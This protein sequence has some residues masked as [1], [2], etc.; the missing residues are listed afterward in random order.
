MRR[1][2]E[3]IKAAQLQQRGQLGH[4]VNLRPRGSL[5]RSTRLHGTSGGVG[6]RRCS[7]WACTVRAATR[8]PSNGSAQTA[9]RLFCWFSTDR[10]QG[11]VACHRGSNARSVRIRGRCTFFASLV[12]PNGLPGVPDA[13]KTYVAFECEARRER[14][15]RPLSLVAPPR[16]VGA[17]ACTRWATHS[18]GPTPV[19]GGG[20][21]SFETNGVV[22]TRT[23]RRASRARGH[24]CGASAACACWSSCGCALRFM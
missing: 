19:G 2:S 22:L 10:R 12:V 13:A 18:S 15:L 20:T 4:I 7:F 9:R 16:A 17:A 6:R 5:P 14:R 24:H 11:L 1:S 3:P 21:R 8:L 23:T